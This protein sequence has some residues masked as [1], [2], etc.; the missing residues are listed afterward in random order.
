MKRV[1]IF[2]ALGEG[3]NNESLE[4]SDLVEHLNLIL[5]PQNI[6]IYLEKWEYLSDS[7]DNL[8][9]EEYADTLGECEICMVVFGKDLGSYTERELRSAYER[10]CKEVVNPSKLYVYFKNIDNLT[11]DLKRFRDSF[12]EAYNG[13]PGLFADTNSLKS[14]ISSNKSV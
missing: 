4:L 2:L 3:L 5:E 1:K 10:V 7:L 9:D 6:H 14:F 11:E 13:S 8:R 12:P